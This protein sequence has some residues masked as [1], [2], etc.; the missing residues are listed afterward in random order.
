MWSL[1]AHQV[2][3]LRNPVSSIT[4]TLAMSPYW[5]TDHK[6]LRHARLLNRPL[7]LPGPTTLHL[8]VCLGPLL[9]MYRMAATTAPYSQPE[10]F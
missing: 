10:F 8:L 9:A 7:Q 5:E 2:S 3:F 1:H 6:F 4:S